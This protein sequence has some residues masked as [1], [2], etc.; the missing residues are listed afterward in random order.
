M[1]GQLLAFTTLFSWAFSDLLSKYAL[2]KQSLWFISFW[3]QLVGG[4]GMLLLGLLLGEI[5]SISTESLYWVALFSIINMFG[6]FFFYKA[7]QHKGVA[8]SLPIIYSWSLP[9][10]F[11]SMIFLN[12]YPSKLQW[13]GITAILLGLFFVGVDRHATRWIDVGSLAALISMLIWGTF[14]FLITEPAEL[15]GEWWI[16]G[17]L[18]LGTALLSLPL[19]IHEHVQLSIKRDHIFWTLGLIG[20]LDGLGLVALSTGLQ[21]SSTAMMTSITSGSPVVVALFGIFLFKEKINRQQA[22][23][24][25]S[26]T[27][28]LILLVI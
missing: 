25:V 24:I 14:Y 11:L 10:I 16:S 18:K 27:M 7:I 9:A 8:L 5:Q 3:V 26:T 6:M 4:A 28:G 17:S 13:F 19:L 12:Q 22:V 23:G 15:Y 21:I 2:K 1:L 20:L